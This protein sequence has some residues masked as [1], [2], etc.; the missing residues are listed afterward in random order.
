MNLGNS[1]FA[2]MKSKEMERGVERVFIFVFVY[3]MREITACFCVDGNDLIECEK[4][5][6]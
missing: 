4:F 5:Y 3:R 1:Y 6:R 2:A